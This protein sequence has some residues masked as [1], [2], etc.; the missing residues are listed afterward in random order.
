MS[1]DVFCIFKSVNNDPNSSEFL[2]YF[3]LKEMRWRMMRVGEMVG[4][5]VDDEMVG[6]MVDQ[7]VDVGK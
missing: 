3:I 6:E 5:M 1:V 4:E 2:N 7:M